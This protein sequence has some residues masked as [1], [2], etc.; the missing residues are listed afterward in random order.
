M[1]EAATLA[2]VSIYE[3]MEY[4]ERE[5]IQTPSLSEEEMEQELGRSKKIFDTI[6]K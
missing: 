6:N 4:I 2:K 5:K 1:A 3:M